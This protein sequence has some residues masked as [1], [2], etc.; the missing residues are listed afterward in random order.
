MV[1]LLPL[2]SSPRFAGSMDQVISTASTDATTLVD[3]GFPAL[4]VEN[5]GDTPFH[6]EKVPAETVAAMTAAVATITETGLPIG[7]NVL[8][9]DAISALG[10]AAAT[11]A[12]FIRVNILTGIMYTDQG[13]ITGRADVVQRTRA[14]LVPHVEVWADVMVKHAVAP[15]GLSPA[16]ATRDTLE[17]GMADAIVISGIGTGAEVDPVQ[18]RSIAEATPSGTRIV[19]GSGAD[20]DNLDRL[21]TIAD[22]VIVGSAI[23]FDGRADNRPD[24]LRAKAFVERAAEKGLL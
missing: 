1:H 10:I 17:R 11:G 5:F 22:T 4:L 23:K 19:I 24:P 9:N 7:V 6:A 18:A 16:Q 8:R 13:P 3:A 21:L 2:P 15:A 12:A 20:V 14:R